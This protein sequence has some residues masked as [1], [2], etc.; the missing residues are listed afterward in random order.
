MS[1]SLEALALIEGNIFINRAKRPCKE[2]KYF[3]TVEGVKVR[4][5]QYIKSALARSALENGTADQRSYERT[6]KQVNKSTLW[7]WA[8]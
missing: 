2:P 4:Y 3:A 5:C 6:K 1:F 8:S 7:N